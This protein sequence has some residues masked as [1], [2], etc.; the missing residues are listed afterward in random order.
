MRKIFIV[1]LI[2]FWSNN[3]FSQL[4]YAHKGWRSFYADINT[5][6]A[7][8]EI[9]EYAP[10]FFMLQDLDECL[11]PKNQDDKLKYISTKSQIEQK[12]GKFYLTYKIENEKNKKVKLKSCKTDYR[13][14]FRKRSYST[15][16]ATYSHKLNDS[17]SANIN[18]GSSAFFLTQEN[19]P[20]DEY[21]KAVDVIFDSINTRILFFKDTT[22]N[23]YY[24]KANAISQID[25]GEIYD[26]LEKANYKNTCAKY[27]IYKLSQQ[28]PEALVNYV[29]KEPVNKKELLNLIMD[30]ERFKEITNNVKAIPVKSSAKKQIVKQKTKRIAEDT[31]IASGLIT[32]VMA[33]LAIIPLLIVWI[34]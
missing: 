30:H 15:K 32:L 10:K 1:V 29:K 22:V 13:L 21:T 9:F 33:E 16:K 34:F 25:S 7:H 28:K 2:L 4:Y 26:L 5:D 20:F 19:L 17:L 3:L 31:A 14:D 12:R 11:K 8:V 27:F 23:L 6:S 18:F 24:M